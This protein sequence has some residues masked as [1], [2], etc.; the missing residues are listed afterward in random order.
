MNASATEIQHLMR[1]AGV[2][3]PA[4][5]A[6]G[7][8]AALQGIETGARQLGAI[9]YGAAEPASRFRAPRPDAK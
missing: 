4:E 1:R 2:D 7:L 8:I 9:D 6:E 3:M 5:R